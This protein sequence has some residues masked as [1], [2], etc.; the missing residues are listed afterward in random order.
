MPTVKFPELRAQLDE[1][2]VNRVL[3]VEH[4]CSPEDRKP[5]CPYQRTAL[6]HQYKHR[7]VY[8]TRHAI[9][10]KNVPVLIVVRLRDDTTLGAV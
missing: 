2:T 8:L 1:L 3:A 9:N 10:G 4:E 6:N 7:R 5:H